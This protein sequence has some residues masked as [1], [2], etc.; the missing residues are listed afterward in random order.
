VGNILTS[1]FLIFD[2]A[3][4]P[5]AHIGYN[6]S[7][8]PSIQPLS[9]TT[10]FWRILRRK[11]PKEVHLRIKRYSMEEVLHIDNVNWLVNKWAEKDRLLSHFARHQEF[12]TDSRGYYGQPRVFNTRFHSTESSCLALIRL[13][14]LP[15]AVPLLVLVAV[16]LFWTVLWIW[17]AHR[18]YRFFFAFIS[19][20]EESSTGGAGGD[21][22]AG[23]RHT[24]GSVPSASGTPFFPATPFASPN[25][26]SWK[27][28]FSCAGSSNNG[29]SMHS[30]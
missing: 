27:D 12:P 6:G 20:D 2:F 3:L 13:L 29:G 5:Q 18:S 8:P 22:G 21:N 19:G 11:F 1:P 10:L 17:L 30:S 15:C 24:P 23:G 14:L 25:V 7:L 26:M 9:L 4:F 16:P 28:M